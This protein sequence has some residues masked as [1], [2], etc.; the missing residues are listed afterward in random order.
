MPNVLSPWGNFYVASDLGQRWC[1][2]F[3]GK[4]LSDYYDFTLNR[5]FL[6]QTAYPYLLRSI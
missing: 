6:E 3:T 4:M 2:G 1:A 5:T